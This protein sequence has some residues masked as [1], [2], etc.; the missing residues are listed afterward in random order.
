MATI[1][2][3]V[4]VLLRPGIGTPHHSVFRSGTH[5]IGALR[6]TGHLVTAM[7]KKIS[8]FGRFV[9]VAISHPSR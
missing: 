9:I 8:L 5:S 2:I 3:T 1:G 7:S 4:H 6:Q